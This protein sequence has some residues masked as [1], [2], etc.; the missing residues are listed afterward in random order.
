MQ[1]K[2]ITSEEKEIK[3][4]LNSSSMGGFNNPKTMKF[5]GNFH[6]R[7][8]VI[9]LDCRATHN[10]ISRTIVEEL[11][12]LVALAKFS[13]TL[14]DDIKVKRGGRCNWVKLEFQRISIIQNFFPFE[15]DSVDIILRVD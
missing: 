7:Q 5:V 1:E 9:L 2:V 11:K 14:G 15:L 4:V 10:F 3:L 13:V 12:L 6:K 8:L